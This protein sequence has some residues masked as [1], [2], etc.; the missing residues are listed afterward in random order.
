MF[1][2]FKYQCE[3]QG[4]GEEERKEECEGYLSTGVEASSFSHKHLAACPGKWIVASVMLVMS[5]P[6]SPPFSR[7]DILL[8]SLTVY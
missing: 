5:H 2:G 6:L 3:V 8:H 7:G 1:S 4:V